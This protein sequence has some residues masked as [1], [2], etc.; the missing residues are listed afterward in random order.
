MVW[1]QQL[2]TVLMVIAVIAVMVLLIVDAGS[3]LAQDED[4]LQIT[5]I[6]VD[7]SGEDGENL[8]GESVTIKN[9]GKKN[10]NVT[11]Y[12]L[13][14]GSEGQVYEFPELRLSPGA[15]VIVRSGSGQRSV[16]GSEPPV[17]DVYANFS[18]PAL[19]NDGSKL[20]L[21]DTNDSIVAR[22]SYGSPAINGF[23]DVPT[24]P[25][26]DGQYED[27][28]ANGDFTVIDVQALFANR[29]DEAV[30]NNP[31]SFDFNQDTVFT[32]SDVQA[33]FVEQRQQPG[34]LTLQVVRANVSGD[35]GENLNEEY[36]LFENTGGQPLNVANYT[37]QYPE[38]Q[39]YT[40]GDIT[41]PVGGTARL[42]TGSGDD[43]ISGDGMEYLLHARYETPMLDNSGGRITITDE[44]GEITSNVTYPPQEE[45]GTYEP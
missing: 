45:G 28:N 31:E 38:S 2:R 33:L 1:N 9:T 30:Q 43:G 6:Q 41:L 13:D 36:L 5:N 32:V 15:T 19:A 18:E 3:V 10:V 44:S 25:D 11:G 26:D 8:N 34:M 29:D 23:D 14:Y 12:T 17:H 24:D 27:V 39:T 4:G 40:F 35:D 21:G 20:T 16:G 7:A 22:R 37:V 42:M